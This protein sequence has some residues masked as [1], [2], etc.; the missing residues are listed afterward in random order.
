MVFGVY[1][2]LKVSGNINGNKTRMS[3][4]LNSVKKANEIR[5]RYGYIRVT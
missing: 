2:A 5:K 4:L 3:A 1:S